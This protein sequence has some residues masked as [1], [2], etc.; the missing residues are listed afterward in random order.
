MSIIDHFASLSSQIS[1]FPR[2]ATLTLVGGRNHKARVRICF[3]YGHTML[4]TTMRAARDRPPAFHR[5]TVVRAMA[6]SKKSPTRIVSPAT[7]SSMYTVAATLRC[8]LRKSATFPRM[9][10]GTPH[11]TTAGTVSSALPKRDRVDASTASESSSSSRCRRRSSSIRR[12]RRFRRS[13]SSPPSTSSS[14]FPAA[15][16]RSFRRRTVD[17][18]RSAATPQPRTS[19]S[20]RLPQTARYP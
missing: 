11:R 4:K 9:I 7:L 1:H 14:S 13:S 10:A 17:R 6:K 19:A 5:S 3:V 16:H 12:R 18:T 20:D 8:P 15:I 2:V